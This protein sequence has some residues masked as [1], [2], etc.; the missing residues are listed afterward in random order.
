MIPKMLFAGVA[1]NASWFVM[2]ADTDIVT[3]LVAA[4]GFIPRSVYRK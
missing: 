1:I 2:G 3:I 4:V